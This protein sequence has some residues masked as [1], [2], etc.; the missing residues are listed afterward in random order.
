MNGIRPPSLDERKCLLVMAAFLHGAQPGAE[1]RANCGRVLRQALKWAGLWNDQLEHDYHCDVEN[2][3]I[4][5][6]YRTLIKLTRH[7]P[8][9]EAL[10][11]GQGNLGSDSQPP[12]F[13]RYTGCRLTSVGRMS[14]ERLFVE[15]P[16]YRGDL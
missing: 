7:V 15:H 3:I 12:A 5:D 13:P 8:L 9:A 4:A 14:A 2:P 10:I 11:E 16:Q 6:W 1:V